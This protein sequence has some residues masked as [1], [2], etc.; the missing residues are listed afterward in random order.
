MIASPTLFRV[1]IATMAATVCFHLPAPARDLVNPGGL[2]PTL[3][4]G[5]VLE[6]IPPS[7]LPPDVTQ[8]LLEEAAIDSGL[9]IA[10]LQITLAQKVQWNDGCL[11]NYIPNTFCTLA[12][13]DGWRALVKSEG[14]QWIYHSTGTTAWQNSEIA[15]EPPILP[16]IDCLSEFPTFRNSKCALPGF[17][18]LNP[19]LPDRAEEE[20]FV[21]EDV[22]SGQWFDPPTTFGFHYVM[23]GDSHFTEILDFPVG[24]DGDDLF[25]VS[26]VDRVLGRFSVGQSVD[27]FALL[28]E[29]V[30]E[31]TIT[32][33]EGAIDPSLPTAFP[34]RLSFNT[35]TASFKMRAISTPESVP[36]PSLAIAL[37]SLAV[38]GV[39]RQ[40]R[41]KAR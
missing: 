14:Q 11:G 39:G 9:P 21:F 34:T 40:K 20:W 37:L 23:T 7:T 25:T 10:S 30:S 16:I 17:S 32:G 8:T 22:E 28:G 29:G 5:S 26:T 15:L 18:Q 24:I 19:I 3:Q 41:R 13:V 33:I 36:E 6:S 31:F 35:S 4:G 1:A 38:L 27:F 12:L 2:P